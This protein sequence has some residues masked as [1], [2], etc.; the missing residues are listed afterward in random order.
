MRVNGGQ[1]E[2]CQRRTGLRLDQFFQ[3]LN[4]LL[5][6]SI[7]GAGNRHG[8]LHAGVAGLDSERLIPIGDGRHIAV[9]R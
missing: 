6:I 4:G 8:D 2:M 9:L 7:L 1:I 3:N 5:G